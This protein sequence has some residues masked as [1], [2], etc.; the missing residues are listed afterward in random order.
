MKAG[1][2]KHILGYLDD[3][4]EVEFKIKDDYKSIL[5]KGY[6]V[7]FSQSDLRPISLADKNKIHLVRCRL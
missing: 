1:E 7:P 2:L 3:N 5:S 4:L 6:K